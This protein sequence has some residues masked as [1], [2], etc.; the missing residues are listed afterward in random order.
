VELLVS[1]LLLLLLPPPP[2]L[3]HGRP[4]IARASG[5]F[6]ECSRRASERPSIRWGVSLGLLFIR[7]Q[8]GV[9]T[10]HA[11]ASNVG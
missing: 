6:Q 4:V 7:R 2:P 10:L 3:T 9:R 8:E 1:T 11:A 5:M